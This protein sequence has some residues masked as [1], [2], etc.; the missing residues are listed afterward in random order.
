[1]AKFE[2]ESTP[3]YYDPQTL[4]TSS[5]SHTV[6]ADT[7][8]CINPLTNLPYEYDYNTTTIPETNAYTSVKKYTKLLVVE[9]GSIDIEKEEEKL[10]GMGIKL[11]VYR[12]GA[13]KPELIDLGE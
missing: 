2:L 6:M 10:E 8:T 12:Q 3:I 5:T 13:Q 9:D 11:L 1:M 4:K 7:K